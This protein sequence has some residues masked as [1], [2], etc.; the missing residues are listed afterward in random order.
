MEER[1]TRTSK[2]CS[3]KNHA[4]DATYAIHKHSKLRENPRDEYQVR[5]LSVSKSMMKVK[6]RKIKKD[7][8]IVDR[9]QF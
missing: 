2:K 6:R 9:C 8:F 1:S 7:Q 5:I 4:T 3:A